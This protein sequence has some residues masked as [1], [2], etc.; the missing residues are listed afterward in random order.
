MK[1]DWHYITSPRYAKWIITGLLVVLSLLI[2]HAVVSVFLFS[3]PV[4][5]S[6]LQTPATLQTKNKE[7]HLKNTLFGEYVPKDL[8]KAHVKK[9]MLNL[10]L[11]GILLSDPESESQAVIRLSNGEEKVYK[12]GDELP[13]DVV[14]KRIM[15]HGVLVEH[16]GGL[17]SLSLPKDDVTMQPPPQPLN[18]E[19]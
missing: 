2:L 12:T 7:H 15:S 10:Q 16:S 14:I 3:Y 11:V 1:F 8:D 13:G 19:E 17:E 5:N 18:T 6:Q 9:S 4:E